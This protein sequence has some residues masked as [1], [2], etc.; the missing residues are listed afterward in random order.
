MVKPF[1]ELPGIVSVVSGY[2]GG[3]TENPTYEEVGSET[4]GHREAVQIVYDPELFPYERLLDIY[5]QLIDPTDDGGQFM[6]RGH[7]YAPAIFIHN[8]EQRKQAELS[9][10]RLKASK[11]FKAPIVTPILLRLRRS[12]LRKRSISTITGPIR[13]IISYIRRA[14]AVTTSQRCTGT[15]VRIRS[16]CGGSS[17]SCNM[18]SPRTKARSLPTRMRIGTTSRRAFTRM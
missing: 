5:W 7:S 12:I 11:R 3:H 16:G 17:R 1:D 15:A 10:E 6:D 9:K 14:R 18:R 2:T 8:E 4:T 13:W